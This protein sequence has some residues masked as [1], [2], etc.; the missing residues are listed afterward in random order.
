MRAEINGKIYDTE[1]A[2][3]R[4]YYDGTLDFIEEF[5]YAA[6]TLYETEDGESFLFCEYEPRWELFDEK[7]RR[8]LKKMKQQIIPLTADEVDEW[9]DG[10]DSIY[11]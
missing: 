9:L 1:K 7:R 4:F 11:L 10:K 2:K 5:L 6:E 3:C 8:E